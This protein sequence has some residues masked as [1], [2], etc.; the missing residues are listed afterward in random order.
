MLRRLISWPQ[1][2]DSREAKIESLELTDLPNR[3]NRMTRLRII[4]EAVSNSEIKV[5]IQDL[6]FGDVYRRSGK[7]WEYRMGV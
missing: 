1:L 2:P 5:L 7:T 6:G 3:P 4:T